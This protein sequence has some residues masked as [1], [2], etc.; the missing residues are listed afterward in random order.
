MKAKVLPTVIVASS[1]SSQPQT[2]PPP[3]QPIQQKVTG[4]C[5]PTPISKQTTRNEPNVSAFLSAYTAQTGTFSQ[6][7]GLNLAAQMTSLDQ[8]AKKRAAVTQATT[9]S[10]RT[11]KA[12]PNTHITGGQ[13]PLGRSD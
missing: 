1:L 13:K 2:K 6:L 3:Q 10:P 9:L 12:T 4:T 8:Y 7:P 11:K 5:A